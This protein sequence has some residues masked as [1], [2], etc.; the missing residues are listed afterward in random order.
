MK[1]RKIFFLTLGLSAAFSFASCESEKEKEEIVTLNVTPTSIEAPGRS[2]ESFKVMVETIGPWLAEPNKDFVTVSPTWSIGNTEMTITVDKNRTDV[3]RDAEVTISIDG[4]EPVTVKIQQEAGVVEEIGHRKFYVTTSGLAE[5]D[6]L[7]WDSA[8][9]FEHAYDEAVAGEEIHFA[10]GTYVPTTALKG[11]DA[12][13]AKNKTFF[14][15]KNISLIGGYSANPSKGEVADPA[16]NATIFSG[17]LSDDVKAFHVMVFGAAIEEGK[18]VL[19]KGIKI[20]DGD[21]TGC[22]GT[23]VNGVNIAGGRGGAFV[24]QGNTNVTLEDCTISDN[25]A[26]EG[27]AIHVNLNKTGAL[28]LNRCAVNNNV[29]ASAS[30][31]I[32][33]TK[34]RLFIYDSSFDG[35]KAATNGGAMMI[36][37]HW[38]QTSGDQ[39]YFYIYGSTF[40]NNTCNG[41][42]SAFYAIWGDHGVIV[43]CTF[44]GNK[45]TA[46]W[47]T[48]AVHMGEVNIINTTITGNS[49]KNV[50][51]LVSKNASGIKVWN[52]IIAGNTS[53]IEGSEN[54][55][56]EN[57]GSQRITFNTTLVGKQLYN[58]SGSASEVAFDPASMLGQLSDNGGYTKTIALV[59]SSNPAV[60]GGLTAEQ[61]SGI[62]EDTIVPVADRTLLAKDQR[63]EARKGKHLGACA[64]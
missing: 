57:D 21:A 59:G 50:G 20:Q 47:G 9:T 14:I 53:S 12:G 31:A 58:A 51:G 55:G 62:A 3:P 28:T 1:L 49:G 64:K 10:A 41:A 2:K 4:A 34:S 16:K 40:T 23:S 54:V 30:G 13:E 44:T 5:A 32:S 15:D 38:N 63:G 7:A 37:G 60:T 26:K 24:V 33:S 61:L 39:S 42:G 36:D 56:Y 11:S 52:S 29:S 6:G 45:N 8:T 48:V 43:N 35:N 19:V 46:Q 25:A 22:P 18:S 27:G 17:K